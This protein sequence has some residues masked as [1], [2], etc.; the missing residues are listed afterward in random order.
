MSIHQKPQ[1]FEGIENTAPGT[2]KVLSENFCPKPEAQTQHYNV[3]N[4]KEKVL[5]P[6]LCI[7][8]HLSPRT[9]P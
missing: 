9:Y 4:P 5:P 3:L 6:Y 2:K 7:L 1:V 8:P